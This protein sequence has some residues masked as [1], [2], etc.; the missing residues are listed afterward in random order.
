MKGCRYP[1]C[2][3]KHHARGLCKAHRR[4]ERRGRDLTPIRPMGPARLVKPMASRADLA[5]EVL[6]LL[7]H[8]PPDSIARRL[9]YSSRHSLARVLWRHGDRAIARAIESGTPITPDAL[10]ADAE[11]KGREVA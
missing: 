3:R 2:Q 8:D 9:G 1:D 11:R 5:E 4:Q 10:R 7:D 6:A